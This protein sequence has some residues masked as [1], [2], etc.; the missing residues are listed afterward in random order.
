MT[1]HK[2]RSDDG[3]EL[4]GSGDNTQIERAEVGNGV[5]NKALSDG[6]HNTKHQEVRETGWVFDHV[7]NS[8]KK[9][10]TQNSVDKGQQTG[11]F[12]ACLHH[13]E[14]RRVEFLSGFTLL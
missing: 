14:R 1:I 11:E 7:L 4:S 8:G 12:V 3:E 6:S 10:Q 2:D 9:F 13:V 5:E